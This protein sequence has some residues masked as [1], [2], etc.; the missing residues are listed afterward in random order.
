[1]MFGVYPTLSLLSL[2]V[3]I[4]PASAAGQVSQPGHE[5]LPPPLKIGLAFEYRNT[6]LQLQLLEV[7]EFPGTVSDTGTFAEGKSPFGKPLP[8]ELLMKRGQHKV[9]AMTVK[10]SSSQEKFFFANVHYMTPGEAGIGIILKCLCINQ[11]FRIPPRSLWYRIGE[12]TI[13]HLFRY[14]QVSIKHTLI[15]VTPDEIKKQRMQ[16]LVVEGG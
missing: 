7:G 9:F 13:N 2:S 8:P 3:A 12:V 4:A 5:A 10:N 16:R 14:Q 15:G 1:M 6:D 11:I